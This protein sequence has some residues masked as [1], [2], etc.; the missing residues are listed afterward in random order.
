MK[1][2][3]IDTAFEEQSEKSIY[4]K[5]PLNHKNKIF[6]SPVQEMNEDAL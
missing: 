6:N 5:S 4:V 1:L 2:K 3:N